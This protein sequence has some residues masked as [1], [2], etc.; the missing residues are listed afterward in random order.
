MGAVAATVFVVARVRARPACEK[1]W[2][3]S[4]ATKRG[5]SGAS[6]G[7]YLGAGVEQRLSAD[8]FAEAGAELRPD[9]DFAGAE[10]GCTGDGEVRRG[11]FYFAGICAAAEDVL[12]AIAVYEAGG[13][14]RGVPCERVGHRLQGR[15]ARQDVHSDYG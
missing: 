10:D 4:S 11:I 1:I 12:G 9:Q 14:R 8:G 6:V 13:S 7:E 2:Q 5:D 15:P 3:R